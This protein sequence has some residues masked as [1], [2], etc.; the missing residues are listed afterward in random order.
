LKGHAFGKSS[1]IRISGEER[2][3]FA[4]RYPAA[5]GERREENYP[6]EQAD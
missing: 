5:A 4:C 3:D 2:R 1:F 6:K